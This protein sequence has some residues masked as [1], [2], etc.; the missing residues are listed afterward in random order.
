MN[1]LTQSTKVRNILAR[2]NNVGTSGWNLK[3]FIKGAEKI[4]RAKGERSW[5]WGPDDQMDG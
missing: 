1:I 4:G 5:M 3:K 2:A